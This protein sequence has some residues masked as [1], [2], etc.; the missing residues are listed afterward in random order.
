[1]TATGYIRG[2]AAHYDGSIY[3][4]DDTDEP[5]GPTWGGVERPC[6]ECGEMAT[7]EGYD[8]CIGFVPGATSVCCG[9]GAERPILVQRATSGLPEPS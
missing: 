1:M 6:P 8:S 5:A 3:R 2:R 9:H 7:A 4:W